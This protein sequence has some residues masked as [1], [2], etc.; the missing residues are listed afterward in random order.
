MARP[1]VTDDGSSVTLDL[2]GA[3]VDE[4]IRLVHAVVREAHAR[5]RSSVRVVHGSST[6]DPLLGNRTIKH[7][8]HTELDAGA[9]SSVVTGALR[10]ENETVLSLPI[11]SR[12]QS[13]RIS[14]LDVV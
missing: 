7:E 3:T 14:L 8:L 2:H 1:S 11:G 6:S 13:A 9:M 10:L 12:N 5:G 4:A